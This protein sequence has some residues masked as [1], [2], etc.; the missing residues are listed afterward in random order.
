MKILKYLF[1]LMAAFQIKP[2]TAEIPDYY[3]KVDRIVWI[4]RDLPKVMNDWRSLGFTDMMDH[5]Q[6]AM[7]SQNNNPMNAHIASANLGGA[8]ITWIQPLS[9]NNPFSDFLAERGD[10]AYALLHRVPSVAVLE[11]EINR[12]R[13]YGVGT[14]MRGSISTDD[15]P[16]NYVFLDTQEKGKYVLGLIT[17]PNDLQGTAGNNKLGMKFSQYAFAIT[18]PEPVSAFWEKVGF[19]PLEI[20]HGETW[21]KEY[22]GKPAD[23]DMKLGW[24]RH[25]DIV[26]EWCIPLKEP[27]VYLDH[28]KS[29]GEGIQ[30]LGYTVQDMDQAIKFFREKG[31]QVSM[32]GG[33]G[34]KGKSGSGR[35]TYIN[36]EEAGGETIELLWS[37]P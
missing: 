4:V 5:G 25:G 19:P 24:Q 20:T 36:T 11:Q 23:F 31:Y 7:S 9:A 33:W 13:D 37:Y 27:T 35:F 34:E 32:S 15:G 12:F 29:H 16:V 26:Y 2:S 18:D 17:G 8:G 3:T 10:G 14:V 21:G 1:I 28:I 30:H 22:Y 6:S